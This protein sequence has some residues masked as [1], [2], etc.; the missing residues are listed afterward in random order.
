MFDDVLQEFGERIGLNTLVF[1][2]NIAMIK[3]EHEGSVY[4]EK[5]KNMLDEEL[6]VYIA[7]EYNIFDETIPY[8][9]LEHCSYLKENI[10]SI[11]GGIVKNSIVL[12][13]RISQDE[14]IRGAELETLIYSLIN[15][16]KEIN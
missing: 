15:H 5:Q 7:K 1:E 13:V 14:K 10:P 4:F 16:V 6:L 9:V 12:G 3:I 11:Y 2:N 8:K